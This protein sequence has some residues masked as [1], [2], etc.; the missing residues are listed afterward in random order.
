MVGR[1]AN[2]DASL[3]AHAQHRLQ[4]FSAHFQRNV[5]V[6]VV[7]PLEFEAH[8]HRLEE[9]RVRTLVNPIK[10]VE[11]VGGASGYAFV[12]FQRSP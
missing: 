11:R 4:I 8:L 12:E 2:Y 5:L 3:G 7:L 10:D 9:R 6:I 1:T